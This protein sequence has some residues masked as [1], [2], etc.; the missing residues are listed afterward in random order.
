MNAFKGQKMHTQDSVDQYKVD[1]YFP[2]HKLAIECDKFGH[3]DRNIEYEVKW[4][5]DIER[6]LGCMFIRYNPDAKDFNMFKVINWILLAL[7]SWLRWL[8]T[9]KDQ[10]N[11]MDKFL[12]V[13]EVM[14]IGFFLYL[15]TGYKTFLT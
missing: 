10:R 1:L 13:Y 2:K 6:R 14:Y 11:K 8:D 9:L 15:V 4:Q 12:S 5:R 7:L 3:L